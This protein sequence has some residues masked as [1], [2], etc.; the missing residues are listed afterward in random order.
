MKISKELTKLYGILLGDG[1]LSKVGKKYYFILITGHAIDD[2]AF[3]ENTIVLLKEISGRQYRIKKRRGNTIEISFS[4]KSLF[5]LL[6]SLEFPVGKKG[7]NLKISSLFDYKSYRHL[8]RGYFATDGSLVLTDN[9]GL[10]YPRIEFSSISKKLLKQ[11]LEYLKSMGMHGNIYVSRK[12]DNPN[13]HTLYRIQCNGK[14]N[15]E[16]FRDKVGFVNPKQ[17]IRYQYFKKYMAV[18]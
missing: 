14:T 13:L 10:L 12:Y 2:R 16:I 15:L 7:I 1:C 4:N 6:K 11:V 8:V 18:A 3:F 5:T 17:E 9:N